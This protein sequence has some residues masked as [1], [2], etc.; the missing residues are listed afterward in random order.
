MNPNMTLK[1]MPVVNVHTNVEP[2]IVF[3]SINFFI[4]RE[5][6]K[7]LYFY[8]IDV[9][10][11]ERIFMVLESIRQLLMFPHGSKGLELICPQMIDC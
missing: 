11:K 6:L 4:V 7:E 8:V 1:F 2:W 5:M 9:I 3:K 10:M